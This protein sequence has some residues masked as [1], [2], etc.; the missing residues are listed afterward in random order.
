MT[1]IN[2]DM[3]AALA[4]L[5]AAHA[6]LRDH[7]SVQTYRL[8]TDWIDAVAAAQQA[9]M[10]AI[11]T[12]DKLQIAQTRLQQLLALRDA[13]S[14]DEGAQAGTGYLSDL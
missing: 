2:A 10:A 3:G 9:A 8:L 11:R 13:L 4:E 14:K 6:A 5:N 12:T 1:R 7:K